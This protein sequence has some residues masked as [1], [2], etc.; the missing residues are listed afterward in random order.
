MRYFGV[1]RAEQTPP[2]YLESLASHDANV[3]R[4]RIFVD[5]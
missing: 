2:H 1:G 4:V 3:E 5:D